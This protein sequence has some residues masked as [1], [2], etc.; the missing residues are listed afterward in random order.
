MKTSWRAL[1]YRRQRG[2]SAWIST[3]LLLA[4]PSCTGQAGTAAAEHVIK[5]TALVVTGEELAWAERTRLGPD[6]GVLGDAF[7]SSVALSGDLAVVGAPFRDDANGTI[8]GGAYVFSRV[9]GDW[10]QQQELYPEHTW[11][12]FGVSTL[13]A[14]GTGLVGASYDDGCGA[15]YVY[16]A[17]S[18]PWQGTQKIVRAGD[19]FSCIN[20]A[21][22]RAI[23]LSGDTLL[24]GAFGYD[25][26]TGAVWVFQKSAGEWVERGHFEAS[27]GGVNDMFGASVQMSGDTAL[28]SAPGAGKVYVFQRTGESWTEVTSLQLTEPQSP[29]GSSALVLSL[30]E[31]SLLVGAPLEGGHGAVHVLF[32]TD[33]VWSEQTVLTADT[34]IPDGSF[35]YAVSLR[36]DTAVVGSLGAT[37]NGLSPGAVFVFHRDGT[38]WTQ[39]Q[40][41]YG[42]RTGENFGVSVSLDVTSLLVGDSFDSQTGTAYA[43]DWG[44]ANGIE[45]SSDSDCASNK[46]VEGI[47]CNE[48]CDGPCVSCRSALSSS[49]EGICDPI[50]SGS[51]P[52][53]QCAKGGGDC[54]LTGSCD[55]SGACSFPAI[56]GVAGCMG[57]TAERQQGTCVAQ[58]DCATGPVIGCATGYRCVDGACRITC[59]RDSDCDRARGYRC[60]GDACKIPASSEGGATSHGGGDDGRA[61]AGDGALDGG[62]GGTPEERFP[63][64]GGVNGGGAGNDAVSNSGRPSIGATNSGA[65]NTGGGSSSDSQSGR[66]DAGMP[67]SAPKGGAL[68]VDNG[69]EDAAGGVGGE[70]SRIPTDTE[71]C[72]CAS[73]RPKQKSSAGWIFALTILLIRRRH[74][75]AARTLRRCRPQ[76]EA[77]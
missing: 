61:G 63:E 25:Q 55:G 66:G 31:G 49:E 51:D 44:P 50:P 58:D 59:L 2:A 11:E 34:P 26:K 20:E 37:K 70:T 42:K 48:R 75:D 43:F 35:G 47:C 5:S 22:G 8:Q 14:D 69:S 56:C 40:K 21:F 36:G 30:D 71:G 7:G 17:S 41:I 33:G 38:V 18:V 73:R 12:F 32:N 4:L 46:C 28:V 6:D 29:D 67:S 57:Q 10:V 24:V 74:S 3:A 60:T 16:D 1:Q 27:D 19:R 9:G 39:S 62:A 23:A 77:Q 53:D 45:C 68:G 64:N 54:G 65:P 15:V 72:A 76:A 13:I 52:L